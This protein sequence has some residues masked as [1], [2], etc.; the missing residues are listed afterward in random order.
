M[1]GFR[2]VR[3]QPTEHLMVYAKGRIA[4]EGAGLTTFY[5]APFSSLVRVPLASVD[6]PFIFSETTAD[7]QEV[8]VQ[9]QLTYRVQDPRKLAQLMNYTLAANG[10]DYATDDPQKLAQRLISHTQVLTATAMKQ[11]SLRQALTVGND[12]VEELRQGLQQSEA[13]G[14]LGI[15]VLALSLLAVKPTLETAR[16]LEAEAREAILR[17]ADD[18]IYARRNAAVEHERAIKENEL[19]TEIAVENKKRQI[20]ETQMEA[21]KA[22]QQKQRELREGEMQ[23]RI[24]LEEQNKVLVGLA[25]A[26]AREEAD[27]KAYAL[28]AAMRALEGVDPRVIQALAGMGMDPAQLIAQAFR[29][30]AQGAERVGQLNV[31]PDLL[32]QLLEHSTPRPAAK[33]GVS[34]RR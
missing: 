4:K 32:S 22:I 14:F 12:L 21:E 19:D 18:A 11:L 9:G 10:R 28:T 24:A 3:V 1:F 26:N 30:L 2:F 15:E 31:S 8:S 33:G 7:F 6:V 34:E 13:I 17:Q 27:A 5:F 25:A 23:T 16:A 20:R 29:E